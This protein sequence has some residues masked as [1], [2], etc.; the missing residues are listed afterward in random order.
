MGRTCQRHRARLTRAGS[1]YI[2]E[3]PDPIVNLDRIPLPYKET[4]SMRDYRMRIATA[5]T[6][7]DLLLSHATHPWIP[8]WDD[9]EVDLYPPTCCFAD[10]PFRWPTMAGARG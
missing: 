10:I 9:H 1:D 3:N 8:V 4:I 2:Y 7:E 6:D 5:R